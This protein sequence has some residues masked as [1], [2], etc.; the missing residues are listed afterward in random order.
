MSLLHTYAPWS[1]SKSDLAG[2][3]PYAFKLRYIDKASRTVGEASKIGTAAHRVQE[4][5][6]IDDLAPNAAL[7]QGLAEAPD[8][9]HG[10][11]LKVAELLPN[12][13][14][15]TERIRSFKKTN[16]I[17]AHYGERSWSVDEKFN[18]LDENSAGVFLR[19]VVDYAMT[20]VGG[21]VIVIDHKSG[22]QHPIEK[23]A[24]QLDTYAV[25]ALAAFPE[26]KGVRAALHYIAT[27]AVEWHHMRDA[28]TIRK[29]L[30]PYVKEYLR[31]RAAGLEGFPAKP[32]TLCKW[33]DYLEHCEAGKQFVAE[34]AETRRIATN[35]KARETRA[36]KK[37]MKLQVV[38]EDEP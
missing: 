8:L 28:K 27:G 3:C 7:K 32:Q 35:T 23:Y 29:T 17:T 34:Q 38:F 1:L 36:R 24:R 12:I 20:T 9:L 33:C 4:L 31:S 13:A 16:P 11:Q 37:N 2:K 18:F 5:M 21:Y 14:S 15:F 26:A 25:L 19:G 6:L 10:E 30:Q 22:R